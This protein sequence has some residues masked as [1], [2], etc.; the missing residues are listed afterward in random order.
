MED[1]RVNDKWDLWDAR[2][3]DTAIFL[4]GLVGT[5][6]EVF[7]VVDASPAKLVFL[8]SLMGLPAIQRVDKKR[9]QENNI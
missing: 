5:I 7:L 8:G 1:R 3:K 6:N 4:A 9:R 2:I